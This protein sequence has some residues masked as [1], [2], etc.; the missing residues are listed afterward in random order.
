MVIVTLLWVIF[1]RNWVC[2][3]GLIVLFL[4]LGFISACLHEGYER[5]GRAVRI[6]RRNT[7]IKFLNGTPGPLRVLRYAFFVIVAVL[8]TLGLAPVSLAT[9]KPWIIGCVLGL[10]AAAL[11]HTVLPFYYLKM[12]RAEEID[13]SRAAPTPAEQI[14]E[15]R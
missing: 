6:V 1:A 4:V 14:I 8:L 9:A 10:F 12:G 13:L 5:T 2:A 7:A 3:P 15:H 11:L